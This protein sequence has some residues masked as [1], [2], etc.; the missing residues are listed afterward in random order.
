MADK[1]YQT[2]IDALDLLAN[3]T[4]KK[5][6]GKITGVNVAAEAGISKASLYRYFNNHKELKN[7]YDTLQKNGI[8]L[9][10]V[11]PETIQQAYSLLKDE[12]KHL[13]SELSEVK[14]KSDQTNKL[15]SHQIQL[16]WMD[17]ERLQGVVRFL[18]SKSE[19]RY[20]VSVL[21]RCEPDSHYGHSTAL[22]DEPAEPLSD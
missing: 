12:V 4:P 19:S 1:N 15:K 22:K 3:G 21:P 8:R 16:L 9:S 20:N 17:N 6:N 18:Q 7:A 14:K 11:A 13:R 5:T 2:I 10:D